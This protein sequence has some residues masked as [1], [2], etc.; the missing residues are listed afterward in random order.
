MDRGR[1]G[2]REQEMVSGRVMGNPGGTVEGD[3]SL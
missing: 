3:S 1:D 2:G